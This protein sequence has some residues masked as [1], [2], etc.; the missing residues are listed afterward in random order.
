MTEQPYAGCGGVLCSS[1]LTW[2]RIPRKKGEIKERERERDKER[3][4][5]Q[6]RRKI[7]PKA[8][9]W[10]RV[11]VGC[12]WSETAPAWEDCWFRGVVYAGR[13]KNRPVPEIYPLSDKAD[14]CLLTT[15]FCGCHASSWSRRFVVFVLCSKQTRF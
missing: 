7:N 4:I 14:N 2:E 12:R 5:H 6:R 11:D 8:T 1:I 10:V 13:T 3:E 9:E 15:L